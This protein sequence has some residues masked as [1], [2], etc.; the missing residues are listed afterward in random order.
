MDNMD[1]RI[2]DTQ[3]YNALVECMDD[4]NSSNAA[5]L[6]KVYLLYTLTSSYRTKKAIR[7]CAEVIIN[8]YSTLDKFDVITAKNY[9]YK[10]GITFFTANRIYL[11]SITSYVII[12]LFGWVWQ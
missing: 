6:D 2:N 7:R 9:K 11:V 1:R 5:L 10:F 8:R 12:D 4:K 3:I